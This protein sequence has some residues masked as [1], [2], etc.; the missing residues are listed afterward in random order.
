M[1]AKVLLS[2]SADFRSKAIGSN[3]I[4]VSFRELL[5]FTR[6]IY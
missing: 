3:G 5:S 6:R 2:F 4:S 1:L